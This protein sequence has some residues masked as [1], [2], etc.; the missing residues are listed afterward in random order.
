MERIVTQWNLKRKKNKFEIIIL[1][2]QHKYNIWFPYNLSSVKNKINLLE[3]KQP[4]SSNF[5]N[6]GPKKTL[7]L[8]TPL[9]YITGTTVLLWFVLQSTKNPGHARRIVVVLLTGQKLEVM[10]DPSTTGQQLFESIITH[11][12]L[13]E[14]FFFGLTYVSGKFLKSISGIHIIMLANKSNKIVDFVLM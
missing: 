10:C 11:I 8:H 9:N 5:G 1:L 7:V 6:L 12:E 14:F 2:K 4:T 3:L 13:P